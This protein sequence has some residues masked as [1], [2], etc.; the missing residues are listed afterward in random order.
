LEDE[1]KAAVVD[2]ECQHVARVPNTP[3]K[4]A[5]GELAWKV[6][7][8]G[9]PK[10]KLR[11]GDA[12]VGDA[13]ECVIARHGLYAVEYLNIQRAKAFADA[14]REKGGKGVADAA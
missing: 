1:H 11:K 10:L 4:I 7:D 3:K 5:A 13:F 9:R 12:N 14:A 8:L 2:H 6:D